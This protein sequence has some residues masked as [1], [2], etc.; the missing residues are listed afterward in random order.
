MS[1][2]QRP[3]K[4]GLYDPQFEHD[5]CGVGFVCN[6]KGGKSNA[7]IKQGIE[8]LHRLSHRGAV[9]SDPKTGDGAGILIQIPDEF[10]Q[11]VA[12][13]SQVALP[14]LGLYG[15]GLIFLP[16]DIKEREFAKEIFKQV[17]QEEGQTLLG[18]R[19]V[20]VDNSGIGKGA[21]A[22]Q[23]V[24]EQVF[25]GRAKNLRDDLAF[26]RKLYIIRKQVENAVRA[27]GLEQ[28]KSFYITNLSCRTFV[29]KGLLM[30]NQLE[31]FFLDLKDESIKSALCLVHSRYSTNTFPTWDLSQPFRF[32]A[33]NG[34]I[35]TLRGNVNGVSARERLL[36]SEL[37][38]TD[39]EKLK[40]VIV[41]GGSDS[42]A[43]DNFFE[44]LVLS[45]RS[46]EHAMMMLIPAAWEHDKLMS[47]ELKDFYKYHACFMEPWDGPAAI[48][49]T[50]GRNIGA[51]LD[52]NGLR[53]ARY[54]VTKND[55]CVMASE[56]GVLD[57]DPADIKVS[58]RLEPGKI[59]FID[60]QSGC[61][62]EDSQ[63]KKRVSTRCP[64]GK[65]NAE[66]LVDLD[67]LTSSG[68]S[69]QASENI[70]PSLGAFGYSREDLKYIIKPMAEE[71][72]EPVGSMGSDIPH[73]IL[74]KKTQVLYNYF[75]QLFAQVTNPAIDS[76]REK[77]VM[78]L[79]SFVGPEKNVLE[80]TPKHSHKLRVKNPILTNEE[81]ARIR[82]ISVN[83]FKAKTIYTFF[84][85]ESQKEGFTRALERICF[86]AEYAIEKGYSFIIL[87]DRQ[88]DK[89]NIALPALL[90]ISAVHHY[91]VKKTIRSQVA[92]IVESA[93][94][95]EVHHI[96]L[97]FGFGADCVNPY[98]AYET[99]E[100]LIKEKEIRLDAKTALKNYHK[101]L[102]D[103]I[104]K[105]LSKMGISTLRSYR[106]AQIFEALGL[107]D[108]LINKYFSGTVSR[109]QGAGLEEI[110]DETIKRHQESYAERDIERPYLASG[111]IYQWKKDGE[112]HLWN[113]ESLASLQDATRDNDYN[114]YKKFAHLINDQSTNPT[115]LRSLFK[116]KKKTPIP[117]DEVEPVENIMKR[118]VTG[119]MS[120]GSISAVAHETI[121]IAMNRIG[122]KSNTGEGGEDP[123]RFVA[124]PNGDSRRS[125]IKQVASGR[126]GVTINYLVN[127]DE[128]QIKIAQ[129]AKPGEGGQLPGHKVSEV[130]ARTRFTTPG[131]TLISPPPHHDIYSIEDLAQLIFD[132]K[133]ANPNARISVKLVSEVGVGTVAAGVAKGHA[134][135][136]LISGGDGGTGASPR[137]SIRYAGLPWEL[138]LSETHQTLMLNNLRSRVR[139]QTDGQMRTGR[140]VAIAAILGA[141]EY[142]FCSAVLV[143]IGCVMLRHCHLN[144]CSV[145]VA[146]QDEILQKRFRGKAQYIVNYFRFVSGELREI[147]SSLGL[148][149]IDEMIGRVDLLEVDRDII[150]FKAKG[151]DYSRILYKPDL[152]EDVGRYFS[153]KQ[154]SLLD[155]VL[156]KDLIRMSSDAIEKNK[157]VRISLEINNTHRALGAM[158]SGEVIRRCGDGAFLEDTIICKFK[159]TAGQS[160]GA[161]LA[162]GITFELEG[163]TNDYVGKGISGGKII[164]YPDKRAKY[165]PDENIIIG[166]TA[167]YGAISGEAYIS[168]V[169][170]ERF[171]IRNSGLYAVV[172]GTGDHGC[173]YMTG[174]RVIVLGK[175]G[176]NFA[177]GMSGGIAYVYDED[178]AFKNRCN[179]DLVELEEIKEADKDTIY[180]LL[181]NHYKYTKSAK[182]KKII[183]NMRVELKNFIK[184]IP[185]EYKRILEGI[186]VEEKLDLVEAFDG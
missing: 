30:P 9:G 82:D 118:F 105:I 37:F 166:N 77:L 141:E 108:E 99:I 51:V 13:S 180:N 8:V 53:P 137:S 129:G 102:T 179:M 91:L 155:S 3:Q 144:N 49:F 106:G 65:W 181:H 87:S 185:I 16:L 98:L 1:H 178:Q 121:A 56:V 52:R 167:F 135:M 148:R 96:A 90:A 89:D 93:E 25:I 173:E 133:N 7:I 61:I 5:S 138:G 32:L 97:L 81:L 35:N 10:F 78:S 183:D 68:V 143:V 132:L 20:P 74:S 169:A 157:Q 54:I 111:G 27:S 184:V 60:T 42:A 100:Y 69:N 175:T 75:K 66:N 79:E 24:F 36:S 83:G 23:P 172:E 58:G 18:W 14:A 6:I 115:T 92:L 4:Q 76:I 45:G 26:E 19:A 103:G 88:A 171:C 48:A 84:A 146:T 162:K 156:D 12:S 168:G 28:K 62:V 145:G 149:T 119:A 46:L 67:G 120:F 176:R 34:E 114:R 170:G 142:G 72:K 126:F 186:K 94:P 43:I 123:N 127:A 47:E 164:I 112:F 70:I 95:R 2:C 85:A 17:I 110:A 130:I 59:F 174:G 154:K 109:I 113:P 104:L 122:G 41:E 165:K 163:M 125:A 101:A 86:E 15:T 128:I 139:L 44:L 11:R 160:F 38:G 71:G 57:I 147:M 152:P 124:S 55:F 22:T 158:L 73:A 161:F 153:S 116:F 177:A 39:T 159:G 117:I 50:D 140:D 150:P 136:I 33:H 63:I 134:D 29:Y 40:P 80:E 31:N 107:D 21:Q 182:A 131:V 64:Y 151:I